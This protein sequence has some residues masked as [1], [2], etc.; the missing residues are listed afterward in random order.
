MH[1]P[2]YVDDYRLASLLALKRGT[3]RAWRC[4]GF[5]PRFFPSG[6]SPRHSLFDGRRERV[7]AEPLR[8]PLQA[9]WRA[10]MNITVVE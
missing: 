5:G 6:S 1:V 7:A 8:Q 2:E 3:L 9:D 4:Q 10:W